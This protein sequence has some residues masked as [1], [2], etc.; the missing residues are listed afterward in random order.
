MRWSAFHKAA[1][2]IAIRNGTLS[3]DVV[4][5]RYMLSEDELASWRADF[6]RHGI[7]G[8][9]VKSM[10]RR[11]RFSARSPTRGFHPT[12]PRSRMD[13]SKQADSP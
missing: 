5:E 7:A 12:D 11:R 2:V 4:R 8:L 9:Q 3:A 6:D 1:V 13:H 10:Q